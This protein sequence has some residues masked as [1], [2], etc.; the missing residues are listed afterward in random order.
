MPFCGGTTRTSWRGVDAR[1][2][3]D[4][5]R[6]GEYARGQGGRAPRPRGSAR[7]RPKRKGPRNGAR[8]RARGGRFGGRARARGALGQRG[9]ARVGMGG[10]RSSRLEGGREGVTLKD[11]RDGGGSARPLGGR[12]DGTRPSAEGQLAPL[13]AG[14]T[15]ARPRRTGVRGS[16]RVAEEARRLPLP[17]GMERGRLP[18]N[19][20]KRG[21]AAVAADLGEGARHLLLRPRTER[22][23]WERRRRDGAER[24][25]PIGG[26][27]RGGTEEGKA[28]CRRAEEEAPA[29]R[30]RR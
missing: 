2:A 29:T 17:S 28:R 27:R 16:T 19:F 15:R 9:S 11:G 12:R 6:D 26:L 30:R 21:G 13:G 5:G 24:E 1:A 18:R 10:R 8:A 22:G 25:A 3:E 23:C 7:A 14:T 4:G 20:G